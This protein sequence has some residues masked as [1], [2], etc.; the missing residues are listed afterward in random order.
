MDW[1][2]KR[3]DQFALALMAIL[4]LAFAVL[5]ILKAQGFEAQFADALSTVPENNKIPPL[6]LKDVDDAK[7]ALQTPAKWTVETGQKRNT[8]LLF[9]SDLYIIGDSGTPEKT[10]V[11]ARNRDSLT[12]KEI[13]NQWFI[14][15]SLP[16]L[17]ANVTQQDPDKDGFTN[18]DEWRAEPPTDP[19][20]KDSHPPYHTKLFLKQ[21]IQVPFR[22]VFKAYDGDPKKDKPEKFSFQIDTI[23][24]RQPS[25]FITLGEMV[26]KTNFKLEKFEFKMAFNKQIDGEEEV[27]ELTLVN[28]ESGV[29]VVLVLNKISNSPDVYGL[30]EY[31]WPQPAQDIKVKKLQEFVLK[32]DVEKRY[33]LVDINETEA[34]IQLP[35]GEKYTVI[36]DPRKAAK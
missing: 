11:G 32:P 5:I 9:A 19:N 26:P 29:K 23:D 3:Y 28:I 25:G 7:I 16:V 14:D 6:V 35:D 4:L 20:K 8:G 15:N 30:F 12:N 34:V 22:L 2:K 36:R 21:F 18:E 33:K 24:L 13:P 27:S 17:D 10:G 1:I 31:E